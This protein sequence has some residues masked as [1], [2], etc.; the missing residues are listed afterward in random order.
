MTNLLSEARKKL[1]CDNDATLT[2]LKNLL[3]KNAIAIN[4]YIDNVTTIFTFERKPPKE[5]VTDTSDE[6]DSGLTDENDV[7]DNELDLAVVDSPEEE[8]EVVVAG[9]SE[10]RRTICN[11]AREELSESESESD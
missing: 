10:D 6:E 9:P 4:D 2:T 11:K 1:V 3:E 7:T 5:Y 8:T